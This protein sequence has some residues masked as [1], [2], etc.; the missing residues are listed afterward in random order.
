MTSVLLAGLGEVGVRAAR[1]LL[2]TPGV[3]RLLIAARPTQRVRDVAASLGERAEIVEWEA[4]DPLPAVDAVA[5]ALPSDLDAAVAQACVRAGVPVALATDRSDVAETIEALGSA[6]RSNG[7]PVVVGAGL[8]PG[9]ACVLARHASA[10][11]DELIEVRVARVGVAGVASEKTARDEL[12]PMPL[13]RR[14]SEWGRGPRLEE[15][16]WFPEPI[17][18]RD[19]QM[20]GSGGRLLA[21]ALS[22]LERLTWSQAEPVKVRK[23]VRRV[24]G[25]D[26]WGS[27]RVEVFGRTDGRVDSVVYGV[28]DRTALAAGVVLAATTAHLAGLSGQ[29]ASAPG[30]HSLAAAV[31]PAAF[32]ADLAHRGVRAAVFEGAPA[33]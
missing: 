17:G 32:L 23:G 4:D 31:E 21:A 13:V 15:L 11:F 7:V 18:A 9:L 26:G 22:P 1:Q 30:V 27:V 19:C 16:V 6:A 29:P 12:R 8:A 2:E 3:E 14:D 25:D 10:L 24:D 28:V 33:I 20:V 5:S